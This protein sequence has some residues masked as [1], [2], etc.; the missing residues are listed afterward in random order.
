MMRAYHSMTLFNGLTCDSSADL[1]MQSHI[2]L[3]VQC[4]FLYVQSKCKSGTKVHHSLLTK[5]FTIPNSNYE[6]EPI[7]TTAWTMKDFLSEAS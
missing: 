4:N 7:S 5:K 3:K 2:E 6:S 1:I